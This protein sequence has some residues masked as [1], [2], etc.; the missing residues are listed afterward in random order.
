MLGL[1]LDEIKRRAERARRRQNLLRFGMAATVLVLLAATIFTGWSMN[2]FSNKLS[3]AEDLNLVRDAADVCEDAAGKMADI[4][5]PERK[6]IMLASECVQTFTEVIVDLPH[7]TVVPQTVV[8]SLE[9]Y[10]PALR[11]FDIEKKLSA[12]QADVLRKAEALATLLRL[13]I[14]RI[15]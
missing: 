10:L 8:V 5:I 6:R 3:V 13:P 15:P 2:F 14:A 1:G 9:R 11:E 7:G 4:R 12:Q